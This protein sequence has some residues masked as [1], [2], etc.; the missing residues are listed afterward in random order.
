MSRLSDRVREAVRAR[1][2]SIRTEE[3]YLR[4]IKEYILF[5]NKR[6]PSGLGAKD[7]RDFV[8]H[9]AVRRNVAASTQNQALSA[10]LFLY[11]E[12]LDQPLE[13]VGEVGRAKRPKKLPV[14]L[15]REEVR[16]VLAHLR[17][18]SWLMASLLYGSGL[19]L[20][21]C[22]RLRVK[23]LD[24]ARLK[25]TV[26][27]GKGG[28]DR[29][30]VL[31]RSLAAPLGGSWSGPGRSTRKTRARA[32]GASTSRTRWRGS[33]GARTGSGAGSTSSRPRSGRS[34]RARGLERSHHIA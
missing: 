12:A 26:R 18:E 8:S 17:G 19:R 15:T 7:V 22:V 33:S 6:H 10:L 16:A 9:L 14:A 29:A 2:Y 27:E 25:L 28:K 31:P 32:S 1:H 13:W 4:W 23:D 21:E 20:M 11:R 24:F 34:T 3:A 30:T 5:F